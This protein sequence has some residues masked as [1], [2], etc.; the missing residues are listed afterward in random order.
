MD[1]PHMLATYLLQIVC[2]LTEGYDCWSNALSAIEHI[3]DE[4]EGS[5]ERNGT[6]IYLVPLLLDRVRLPELWKTFAC[7]KPLRKHFRNFSSDDANP[8]LC[9]VSSANL[10]KREP[11]SALC[12]SLLNAIKDEHMQSGL[13]I[14]R[15]TYTT[16]IF[17]LVQHSP[18]GQWPSNFAAQMANEAHDASCAY[19]AVRRMWESAQI[20][21]GWI[22]AN[23]DRYKE[24]SN[25][26][27]AIDPKGEAITN[28]VSKYL[29]PR[30]DLAFQYVG[31]TSPPPP[32]VHVS[33]AG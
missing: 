11:R 4:E 16:E 31:P 25:N 17:H 3:D 27:R 18:G 5:L 20:P 12:I 30:P 28:I 19:N 21:A 26:L 29:V 7:S 2:Y 32:R 10:L 6:I 23:W 33:A 15:S 22:N 1:N 9:V 24:H 14:L 13:S 8:N